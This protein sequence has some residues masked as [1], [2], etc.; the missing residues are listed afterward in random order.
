MKDPARCGG[1]L[2]GSSRFTQES[3]W[4]A[5]LISC[6]CGGLFGRFLLLDF[7]LNVF[8]CFTYMYVLYTCMYYTCASEAREDV[9]FPQ[10]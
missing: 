2:G 5:L 9:G 4:L 6:S 7:F 10:N 1:A 3:V 8:E